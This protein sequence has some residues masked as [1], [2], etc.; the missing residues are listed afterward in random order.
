MKAKFVNETLSAQG[1]VLG[2]V[3][4]LTS[5]KK[6]ICMSANDGAAEPLDLALK[7]IK[8]QKLETKED[9]NWADEMIPMNE[10]MGY[11]D[12]FGKNIS[13]E[14]ALQK[15]IRDLITNIIT[16]ERGISEK[17]FSAYDSVIDEV[18]NICAEN[19]EIYEIANECYNQNK[20]LELAAEYVYSKYFKNNSKANESLF[21]EEFR[22]IRFYYDDEL[23][24][25]YIQGKQV[26]FSGKREYLW[27]DGSKSIIDTFKTKLRK[28]SEEE[29]NELV[30]Q[31]FNHEK[32]MKNA[33]KDAKRLEK[34]ELDESL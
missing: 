21:E 26:G 23:G 31:Y 9:H 34:E 25:P 7:F 20:R 8:K 13:H 22:K 32:F 5:R 15:R 2:F 12:F 14:E 3:A 10:S 24:I 4:W 19:P 28:I 16:D 18:K 27:P 1:A 17:A 33:Y 29:Y 11:T 6:R 30:K